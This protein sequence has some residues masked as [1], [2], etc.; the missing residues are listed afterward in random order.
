MCRFNRFKIILVLLLGTTACLGE[1]DN[2]T[3]TITNS[4]E[5]NST[6][7]NAA[8]DWIST[9]WVEFL[10]PVFEVFLAVLILMSVMQIPWVRKKIF[11]PYWRE[12]RL[13]V[14]ASMTRGTNEM[15]FLNNRV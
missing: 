5:T 12:V 6:E 3:I 14:S 9:H 1:E 11:E 7:T 8:V 10:F 4:T 15:S 13:L 2:S